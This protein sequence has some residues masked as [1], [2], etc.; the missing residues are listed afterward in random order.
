[1]ATTKTKTWRQKL[2]KETPGYPKTVE[3]PLRMARTLGKGNMIILTPKIVDTYIKNIPKGSLATINSI[4]EHF[5][6]KYHTAT[7]CPITT[8]IFTWISAGAA[9]ED[10]TAGKKN[11]TPY[12]R[13]LKEG[14]KLNPRYPGGVKQQAI[15]LQKEGFEILIGKT[16]NNWK[17]KDYENFITL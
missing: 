1:M 11:I 2:E 10:R 15:Y 5:A 13:V 6:H 9:E 3:I 12:W 16:E 17:V 8:G 14:G 7:T 4:R